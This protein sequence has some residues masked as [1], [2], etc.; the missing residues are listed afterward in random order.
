VKFH[1][2]KYYQLNLTPQELHQIFAG[3]KRRID[4]ILRSMF[5]MSLTSAGDFSTIKR[6]F[7]SRQF[8]RLVIPDYASQKL[9]LTRFSPQLRSLTFIHPARHHI[10]DIQPHNFLILKHLN[11][12]G[13]SALLC[14]FIFSN[15]FPS[16]SKVS[17]IFVDIS[18]EWSQSPSIRVVNIFSDNSL[19]FGRIIQ[20]CPNIRTL[21]YKG[22]SVPSVYMLSHPH[23]MLKHLSLTINYH[24]SFDTDNPFDVLLSL[25]PNSVKLSLSACHPHRD[26]A[27]DFVSLAGILRR[28]LPRLVC[29]N[30]NI[31]GCPPLSDPVNHLHSLFH[32]VA[33]SG[34]NMTISSKSQVT[35]HTKPHS[36]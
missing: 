17:L 20:A 10:E 13:A 30:V 11:I 7:R 6:I 2:W 19:D 21:I 12:Q 3:L 5:N 18:L 28:C 4:S 22:N 15:Q 8:I 24:P 14:H 23:L 25:F 34:S 26:L 33:Y 16:L 9:K 27:F 1:V 35:L 36:L 32:H 29:F 31:Q